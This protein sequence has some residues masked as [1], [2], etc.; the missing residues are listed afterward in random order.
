MKNNN[1]GF[2]FVICVVAL[3]ACGGGSSVFDDPFGGLSDNPP[4][5]TL[6][7]NWTLTA[8]IT[9]ITAD[10]GDL[11]AATEAT[12]GETMDVDISI[13]ETECSMYESDES[14]T[15]SCQAADDT[16]V[17]SIAGSYEDTDNDCAYVADMVIT[18]TMAEDGTWSGTFDSRLIASG[19][20]AGDLPEGVCEVT[21][22]VT[23]VEIE[24]DVITDPTVVDADIDGYDSDADCN[25]ADATIYPGATETADDGID[26]DCDGSDSVTTVVICSV[27][28]ATCDYDLDDDG[29]CDNEAL[30]EGN[31]IDPDAD[32]ANE[33]YWV[34]SENGDSS[35]GLDGSL[36]ITPRVFVDGTYDADTIVVY[37]VIDGFKDQSKIYDSCTGYYHGSLVGICV[38]DYNHFSE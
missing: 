21:G 11:C 10:D 1:L 33:W 28:D 18:A 2:L 29:L 13:S 24:A 25:D 22:T 14:F 5:S 7:A 36:K 30:C 20:C 19:D 8:E 15:Y 6:V 26:Q 34:D 12:V 4:S 3:T 16:A 27:G 23:G 17:V 31:D 38:E 9:E 35:L 37:G 32:Y